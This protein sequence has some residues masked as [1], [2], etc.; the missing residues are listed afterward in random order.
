MQLDEVLMISLRGIETRQRDNLGDDWLLE[1]LRLIELLD[2]SLGDFLLF[3]IL[4]EDRRAR[5]TP[6]IA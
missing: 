6:T 3:S 2:V 5:E 4:I 1:Q